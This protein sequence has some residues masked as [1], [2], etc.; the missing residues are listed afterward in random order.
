VLKRKSQRKNKRNKLGI[1]APPPFVADGQA[2]LLNKRAVMARIPLSYPSI[3]AAMLRGEFPRSREVG[4]RVMWLESEIEAWI[5]SRPVKRLKGEDATT[6]APIDRQTREGVAEL[7]VH[8]AG[9]A[10]KN[11]PAVSGAEVHATLKGKQVLTA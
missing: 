3:W 11:N 6:P 5:T 7:R 9:R 10:E 8:T 1:V 4:G 2:R